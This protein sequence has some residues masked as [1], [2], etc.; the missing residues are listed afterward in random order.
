MVPANRLQGSR[1]VPRTGYWRSGALLVEVVAFE[2]P[3]LVAEP[4][5]DRT[6]LPLRQIDEDERLLR[7]D[8]E[9]VVVVTV[10]GALVRDA[11]PPDPRHADEDL[12]QIVED[13][14]REVLD[15]RGAHHQLAVAGAPGERVEVA[16]VLDPG[17]V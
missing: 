1:L 9:Q 16:V 13:G 12:E 7:C 11:R 14:R 8:H 2:R 5:R 15:R 10:G 3:N 17:E 6:R 4:V